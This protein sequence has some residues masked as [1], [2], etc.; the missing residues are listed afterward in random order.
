LLHRQLEGAGMQLWEASSAVDALRI[1]QEAE[2][3]DVLFDIALLDRSMPGTDGLALARMIDSDPGLSGLL[4]IL[5]SSSGEC[6]EC[7]DVG[8]GRHAG[9]A[10][11]LSKPLARDTLRRSISGVLAAR[12]RDEPPVPRHRAVKGAAKT[13]PRLSGRVLV[14][15]DVPANQK[16]VES[17]LRRLGLEVEVVANGGEAVA[18]CAAGHFDLILMDCQMPEMDGF[19]ATRHIREAEKPPVNGF[20]SS[21]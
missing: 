17:M 4:L 19:E 1:L 14:A 7:G 11:C 3:G 20:P 9:F 8:E 12:R 16:V 13:A 10:A 5:L 15:E 18:C 2:V 6:G 21:P